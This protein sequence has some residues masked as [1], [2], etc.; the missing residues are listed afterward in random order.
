LGLAGLFFV[1]AC[2]GASTEP[3]TATAETPLYASATSVTAIERLTPISAPKLRRGLGFNVD[4][5]KLADL[6]RAKQ[7]GA[8][9]VRMQFDW[10]AVERGGGLALPPAYQAALT[11]A[12]QLG[13]EPLL[14]AAY[15]PPWAG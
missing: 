10:P 15:G 13:L 5:A 7:I 12:A 4:P 8:T 3:A 6:D 9:E 1:A 11:R 2:G 14:I